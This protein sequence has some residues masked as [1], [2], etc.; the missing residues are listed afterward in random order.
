[1]KRKINNDWENNSFHNWIDSQFYSIFPQI[2]NSPN[3]TVKSAICLYWEE[4]NN[5]EIVALGSGVKCLPQDKVIDY[6]EMNCIHDSHAE[7]L[8]RRAFKRYLWDNLDNPIL[9]Q[10]S[11]TENKNEKRKFK[12]NIKIIFYSS[13]VPCGDASLD[14]K[15][16]NKKEFMGNVIKET[17]KDENEKSQIDTIKDQKETI[18]DS[19]NNEKYFSRGKENW[20][21][22]RVCRTK[23]G[24]RDSPPTHSMSCSDKLAL[25][26]A[27][28][29]QGALLSHFIHEPIFISK[30]I[31]KGLNKNCDYSINSSNLHLSL[32][33]AL[34]SRVNKE[35]RIETIFDD[36]ILNDHN[37]NGKNHDKNNP[38]HLGYYWWKS[39]Q[40]G[41]LNEKSKE[42]E[43]QFGI[44]VGGLLQGTTIG[45]IKKK[46]I[47]S[48]PI[49]IS[50]R[51][52]EILWNHRNKNNLIDNIDNSS[53]YSYCN[54]IEIK[55]QALEYQKS[56][57]SIIE[58]HLKGAWK[59]S[60]NKEIKEFRSQLL[61]S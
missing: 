10:I 11:N 41:N 4:T 40:K 1:M 22:T 36:I 27:I 50:K 8:C 37:E 34:N 26:N 25:W 5:F 43:N 7:I 58:K 53:N 46:K 55:K 14:G 2:L 29:I 44:L 19:S 32:E 13:H 39:Q 31:I 18:S 56:K 38:S 54:Y 6:D 30:F 9:F 20:S 42:I 15:D 16:F 12:S 21:L 48:N 45:T 23:P 47:S 57:K 61:I 33:R 35:T 28:G 60:S 59:G 51:A 49:S 24:R 3:W 17:E 52:F